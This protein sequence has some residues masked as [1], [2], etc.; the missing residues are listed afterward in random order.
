[1]P[2]NQND[3][4]V[5]KQLIFQTLANSSSEREDILAVLVMICKRIRVSLRVPKWQIEQ[6][7]KAAFPTNAKPADRARLNKFLKRI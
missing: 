5:V 2:I 1:M 3:T 6:E 4:A 7:I